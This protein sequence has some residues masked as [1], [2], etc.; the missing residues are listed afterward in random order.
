MNVDSDPIIA[1]L[2]AGLLPIKITDA[3]DEIKREG[4]RGAS[5]LMPLVF[6]GEWKVILTQRPQTMPSHAGQVAFPGGKRE[7]GETAEQAALRETEEEIGLKKDSISMLGRLPSFNATSQFR[8]TPFVGIVD[9]AAKIIPDPHEVADV[10]ETPLKFLMN[11]ENHISRDVFFADKD[12]RF[13]DMPYEE[14]DGT[15]R[16]IWGMT[17]MVMYRLYQRAYLGVFETDY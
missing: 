10:F 7:A 9:P 12:H 2:L 15:H 11:P 4:Q 5:V 3:S 6:R 17:A 1:K 16:N 8:V 14:P 13:Y